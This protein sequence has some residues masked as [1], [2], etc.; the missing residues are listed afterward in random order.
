MGEETNQGAGNAGLKSGRSINAAGNELQN[1][2]RVEARSEVIGHDAISRIEYSSDESAVKY[3][4][5]W[6]DRFR[7]RHDHL[8]A[9]FLDLVSIHSVPQGLSITKRQEPSAWRRRTSAFLAASFTS[10]PRGAGSSEGP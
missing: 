1:L 2:D 9:P 5:S 4:G 6:G 7:F 8:H 10:S 3:R